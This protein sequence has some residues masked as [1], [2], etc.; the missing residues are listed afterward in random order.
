MTQRASN[1]KDRP[2]IIISGLGRCGSSL[3]MQMLHAGGV[4]CLGAP[5]A[6]EPPESSPMCLTR[7]WMRGQ[8]GKAF[9]L[10]DPQ[11]SRVAFEGERAVVVLLQR[12]VKQQAASM[13]K[14]GELVAGLSYGR[15]ERRRLAA[16]FERDLP[17]ARA[18]FATLPTL[19]LSFERLI[20]EP[21]IAA[22]MLGSALHPYGFQLDEVLAASVVRARSPDCYPGLLEAQLVEEYAA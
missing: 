18:K 7:D 3:V 5:P 9:K 15:S 19:L 10:L 6:F 8:A 16:S 4:E 22:R 1:P 11:L 12:D 13:A 21:A 14:F 20:L 2:C 17:K